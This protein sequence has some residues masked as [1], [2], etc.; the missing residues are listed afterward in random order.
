MKLYINY[1][2]RYNNFNDLSFLD[3]IIEYNQSKET[4]VYFYSDNGIYEMKN[5]NLFK[6]QICDK[7]D[8]QNNSSNK[9][10]NYID[11]Y[12]LYIDH[13]TIKTMREESYCLPVNH[14][15]KI[16]QKNVYSL[17]K[18]SMVRF[19]VEIDVETDT[20]KDHYFITRDDPNIE[21]IKEDINTFLS[22][23]K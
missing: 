19:V 18:N 13:T 16:I 10:E 4:N 20:I 23:I 21:W 17:A 15:K 11:E 12:P 9:V 5:N 3:D 22:L 1:P 2:I 7:D 8:L 6:L 14:I